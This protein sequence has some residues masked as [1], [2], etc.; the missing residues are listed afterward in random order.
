[1]ETIANHLTTSQKTPQIEKY[2]ILYVDD[3]ETNL[4]IFKYAFQRDYKV[5]L[6]LN[7]KDAIEIMKDNDIHLI[8]T[9][10]RMPVMTGVDL[11]KKVV[12]KHPK[13]V[14]MIM[15]GFSD[16]GVLIDAVNDIGINKYLKK[17]WD[18]NDLKTTLDN[19][20]ERSFGISDIKISEEGLLVEPDDLKDSV[21][22][23]QKSTIISQEKISETFPRSVFI[24]RHTDNVINDVHWVGTTAS[25]QK[26]IVLLNTHLKNCYACSIAPALYGMITD[27]VLNRENNTAEK[28]MSAVEKEYENRGFAAFLKDKAQN[29]L[30]ISMIMIDEDLNSISYASNYPGLR[31]SNAAHK[32]IQSELVGSSSLDDVQR[33]FLF[34]DG[35][36][37]PCMDDMVFSQFI[38]E[39]LEMEFGEQTQFLSH[40]ISGPGAFD[41]LCDVTLIGIDLTK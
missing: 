37:T 36:N 24:D 29:R 31:L 7:G 23:A 21:Q 35:F 26:A 13:V 28:L 27:T 22:F 6:A 9:D 39:S 11:L 33:V 17:P 8:I 38:D 34:S 5:F 30:G 12:P 1:M 19:E 40:E 20:L 14:R 2:N 4:R 15:T 32:T 10:Q 3:E 41:G 18:R 25:G 16:V